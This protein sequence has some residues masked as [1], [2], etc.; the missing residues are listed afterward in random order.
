MRSEATVLDRVTSRPLQWHGW[1]AGLGISLAVK[2]IGSTW[3][4]RVKDESGL[5]D[6]AKA[7]PVIFC[8]WH[9]RLALSL[10]VFRRHVLARQPGRQLAALVSA[11]R[12]G[13]LLADVLRRFGVR[14]VRGSSSRRGAQAVR[15]MAGCAEEGCD[16]AI[17]PDGPRGP[18]YHAQEGAVALAQM[19]GH[20]IVPTSAWI[21][22]K[23]CLGSWDRFQVPMPFTQCDVRFGSPLEV[24]RK[25]DDAGREAC[26]TELEARLRGITLD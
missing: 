3:R 16:L 10:P 7:R 5:F 6:D 4:I 18:S 19:T 26:R 21:Q 13:A 23:K 12:D 24:P 20:V 8:M 11:S 9:N 14:A 15:E 22:W 1:L 2:A 25:L 17:T